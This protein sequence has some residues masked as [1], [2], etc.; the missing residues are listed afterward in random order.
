MGCSRERLDAVPSTGLGCF[1]RPQDIRGR[2]RPRC[3]SVEERRQRLAQC[4]TL[5]AQQ[6]GE[7]LLHDRSHS[8]SREQDTLVD[9]SESEDHLWYAPR[10]RCRALSICSGLGGGHH[11]SDGV[12]EWG[13]QVLLVEEVYEDGQQYRTLPGVITVKSRSR[14]RGGLL[15]TARI[16]VC[17]G[18]R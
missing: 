14:P 2:V 11:R 17:E 4:R 7:P 6:S 1:R 13:R 8:E 3:G 9:L 16:L 15:A 10:K 12:V 5:W 18:Y